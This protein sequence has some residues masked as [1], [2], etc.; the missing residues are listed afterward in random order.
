[1]GIA[2]Y[3]SACVQ[4]YC[5]GAHFLSLHVSTYMA[6]FRCVRYFIFVCLKDTASQKGKKKAE[7]RRKNSSEA[8]SFKNM[9]IKY[10]THLKMAM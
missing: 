9:K 4:L 7:R 5:V 10:R 1:M 2:G 3:V 8:E 6:I